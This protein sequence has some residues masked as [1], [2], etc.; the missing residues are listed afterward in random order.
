MSL[1][2]TT[3]GTRDEYK[4]INTAQGIQK[5]LANDTLDISR[6]LINGEWGEGKTEFC[7]KMLNHLGVNNYHL[8][9]V[10][11]FASDSV[12]NPILTLTAEIAKLA[13]EGNKRTEL[14][15]K[16]KPA[17]RTGAKAIGKGLISIATKQDFD[18]LN[19][20]FEKELQKGADQL[21]DLAVETAL[22]DQI[23]AEKNIAALKGALKLLTEGE[24]GKPIIICIDEFDRCRPPYAISMLETVKHV[25]DTDKV[26]FIFSANKEILEQSIKHHYG[27]DDANRYLDKFI[28]FSIE[29]PRSESSASGRAFEFK[30]ASIR[31]LTSELQRY[32]LPEVARMFIMNANIPSFMLEIIER[33]PT[34]TLRDAEKLAR[35][36]AILN[37]IQPINWDDDYYSCLTML[38]IFAY[39]FYKTDFENLEKA[40]YSQELILQ[41]FIDYPDKDSWEADNSYRAI[42]FTILMASVRE[43]QNQ[44]FNA[45]EEELILRLQEL[46]APIMKFTYIE[47]IQEHASAFSTTF[48]AML[49]LT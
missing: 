41:H 14:I 49:N 37:E 7:H 16:F 43:D 35:N 4:R 31:H 39:T 17:L 9:Y 34:F 18:S 46:R 6:L 44:R 40:E 45:S 26:K 38:G 22:K 10:D 12:D 19:D 29:L 33:V 8:V 15:K 20:N 5:L 11:A 1:Q 36:I 24:D 30:R 21:T 27:V 25:F 23:E 47:D 32:H 3:F 48:R 13:P 2:N 42:I 28:D